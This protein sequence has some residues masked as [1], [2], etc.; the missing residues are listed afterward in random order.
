MRKERNDNIE[1]IFELFYLLCG[2]YTKQIKINSKLIYSIKTRDDSSLYLFD[3]NTAISFRYFFFFAAISSSNANEL[4]LL[5]CRAVSF[6]THHF[7][8][9]MNNID[10]N[11]VFKSIYSMANKQK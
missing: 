4:N 6:H 3:S 7:E 8:W 1:S 9:A 10:S 5:F 2:H 11:N